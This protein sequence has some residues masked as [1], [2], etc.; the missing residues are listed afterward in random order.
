M[1]M[2][3]KEKCIFILLALKTIASKKKYDCVG[4]EIVQPVPF[5]GIAQKKL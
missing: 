2:A 4:A 5:L 3:K 1:L